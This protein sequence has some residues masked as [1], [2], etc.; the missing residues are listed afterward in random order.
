MSQA[1][2]AQV[3]AEAASGTQV[4]GTAGADSAEREARPLGQQEARPT[5][6]VANQTERTYVIAEAPAAVATIEA[7]ADSDTGIC[8]LVEEGSKLLS[9][10]DPGLAEEL[11]S[12]VLDSRPYS[13][14]SK[15]LIG[16]SEED[17]RVENVQ[18]HDRLGR[19][20]DSGNLRK[21]KGNLGVCFLVWCFYTHRLK[22]R[23]T[24]S[25]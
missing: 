23:E 7:A 11:V 17:V 22:S 2:P 25:V 6:P 19:L 12:A 15:R 5:S 21:L 18:T 4:E 14:V 9:Q 13:P 10:L 24:Y 16:C 1:D 3:P 8:R 20:E